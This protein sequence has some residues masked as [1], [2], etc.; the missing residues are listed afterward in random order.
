MDG[1]SRWEFLT[2]GEFQ[3]ALQESPASRLSISSSVELPLQAPANRPDE[4][5]ASEPEDYLPG[6][7]TMHSDSA[8]SRNTF[9]GMTVD[10]HH[11]KYILM[12]DMLTGI[13]IAVSRCQGQP[14]RHTDLFS[15]ED[16]AESVHLAFDSTGTE[17]T[18]SSKYEFKFKDYAPWV[19]HSL[20]EAFQIDAADYLVCMWTCLDCYADAHRYP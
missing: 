15:E 8:L 7:S 10:E 20:R 16:F 2:A 9:P 13:R 11:S 17:F 6:E 12:Y 4:T 5:A 3:R 19:F 18:P 1:G 14:P